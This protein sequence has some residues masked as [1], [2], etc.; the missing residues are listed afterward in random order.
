MARV[1]FFVSWGPMETVVK[2]VLG[3]AFIVFVSYLSYQIYIQASSDTYLKLTAEIAEIEA[4]NAE[5][6]EANRLL[7]TRIEALRS[8]PRAIE[9]K[10]RD[11]LGMARTDEVILLFKQEETH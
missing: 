4:G 2:L 10:V 6:A 1:F 11:E 3:I 8:D 5:R 7:R 9:R